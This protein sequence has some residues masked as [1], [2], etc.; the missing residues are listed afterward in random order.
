M[1]DVQ[2][3]YVTFYNAKGSSVYFETTRR[4]FESIKGLERRIDRFAKKNYK[5]LLWRFSTHYERDLIA[6]GKVQCERMI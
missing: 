1:P 6:E 5:G 4:R 3:Y 2:V